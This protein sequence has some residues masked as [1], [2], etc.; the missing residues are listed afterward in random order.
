MKR[1]EMVGC[2][3]AIVGSIQL[4]PGTRLQM[5]A[6]HLKQLQEELERGD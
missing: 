2:K 1:C 3:K 6:E 5:C 4:G